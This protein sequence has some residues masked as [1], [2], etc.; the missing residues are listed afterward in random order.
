MPGIFDN[1]N[2]NSEVF[3]KYL[4]RV[5]NLN[6]NQLIKSR[7][8]RPRP[9]LAQSMSDQVGGNYLVTP[10]KGL[11]GG[12]PSNYDGQSSIEKQHTKTFLHSRVVVGRAQAWTENDFSYDITGGEDFMQNVVEQVAQ[13][14][15]E[16]DQSTILSILK[17]VF[18][19]SGSKNAEFVTSHTANICDVVNK[20]GTTGAMDATTLNTAMQ[21]ACGDNKGKFSLV[22]MHS[23]VATGLEN[24]NLLSYIKYNDAN[25]MQRDT[26]MATLNGRLVLIDDGMPVSNEKDYLYN[27]VADGAE[28]NAANTYYVEDSES[29]TGYRTLNAS[30][31][32]ASGAFKDSLD[33]YLREE[34][35]YP[36]Y[37]TYVL[38]DGAIEYTDCG[39]KVPSEV[40]RDPNTN[41]GQ[42]TLYTR[43]RKSFAP[44]GI[45]F[46]KTVMHTLSPS[47]S[48]L[49]D[50]RNWEL[51][52]T[53]TSTGK[54]YID[55]KAIPIARI[56]SRA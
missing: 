27:K 52:S 25:G 11:I 19:M 51:V 55:P 6:R 20:E 18:N 37:T 22:I 26:G 28:Y 40:F 10:L 15:D 49:E 7:A 23:A 50:G 38:G 44:Y 9:E 1:K 16:V 32:L 13:Y 36:A 48:D 24:L 45:S 46:T 39:A 14:W 43:Q 12:T 47:V 3:Q 34:I 53:G 42:D 30:T 35:P 54:E 56:I 31:D 8:V 41:G 17:G 5:P 33:Y 4:E 29:A 21:K 2:F